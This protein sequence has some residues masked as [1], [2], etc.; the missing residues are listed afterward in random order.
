MTAHHHHHRHAPG[1]AHPPAMVAPSILRLSAWQ[2]LGASAI[3]IVLLWVAVAWA[4]G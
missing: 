4:I 2:R 3:L 1:H